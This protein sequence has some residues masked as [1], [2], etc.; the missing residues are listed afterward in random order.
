MTKP[1]AKIVSVFLGGCL[2]LGMVALVTCTSTS[3]KASVAPGSV[4]L[5]CVCESF[6]DCQCT[7]GVCGINGCGR[8]PGSSDVVTTRGL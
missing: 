8:G 7:S 2:A 3:K 5:G 6:Q 4:Q 1:I